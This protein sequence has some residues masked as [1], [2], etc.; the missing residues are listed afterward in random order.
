MSSLW[1]SKTLKAGSRT[2]CLIDGSFLSDG[3]GQNN[4]SMHALLNVRVFEIQ[5]QILWLWSIN[6]DNTENTEV[7][8][9][10]LHSLTGLDFH[11]H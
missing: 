1:L 3:M 5:T 2:K 8:G 7:N 9:P 4:G 11:L 6:N 10:S